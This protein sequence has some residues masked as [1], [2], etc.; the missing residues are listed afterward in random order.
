MRKAVSLCLL[1]PQSLKAESLSKVN[2]LQI[3]AGNSSLGRGTPE[4]KCGIEMIAAHGKVGVSQGF[5]T[6]ARLI[7]VCLGG[8][9]LLQLQ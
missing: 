3:L 7:F 9:Q 4:I 2:L 6:Q 5:S 8:G 1:Q